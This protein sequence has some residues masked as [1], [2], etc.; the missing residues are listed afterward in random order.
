MTGNMYIEYADLIFSPDYKVVKTIPQANHWD[1]TWTWDIEVR[2]H[3]AVMP[4]SFNDHHGDYIK[5]ECYT[6]AQ[7]NEVRGKK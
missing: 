3:S 7:V 6:T 5:L 1:P 4:I 2:Q